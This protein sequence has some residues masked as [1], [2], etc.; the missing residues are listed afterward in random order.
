[1]FTIDNT[2][3]TIDELLALY[4]ALAKKGEIESCDSEEEQLEAVE[5]ILS[6][7]EPMDIVMRLI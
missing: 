5:E 2:S 4:N 6:Y 7:N 3:F 1:M